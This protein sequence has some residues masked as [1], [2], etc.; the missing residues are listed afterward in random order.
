MWTRMKISKKILGLAAAAALFAAGVLVALQLGRSEPATSTA[1]LDFEGA[2]HDIGELAT[3][4]YGY[5]LTQ[6]T[7]KEAFKVLGLEIPFTS[8]KIIYSYSGNVK[9]GLD[10]TAIEVSVNE[11][12]KTVRVHLPQAQI[13]SSEVDFNSFRVYDESSSV[14]NPLTMEDLNQGLVDFQKTGDEEAMAHGVL[15]SAAENAKNLLRTT[16]AGFFDPQEYRVEFY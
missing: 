6:I 8:S 14:F 15:D 1:P 11:T 10:F 16:F 5:T 3:A 2:L 9:A 7:D 13:L 12:T 4:E